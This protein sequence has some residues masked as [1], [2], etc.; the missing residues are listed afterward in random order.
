VIAGERQR[1]HSTSLTPLN[2]DR[3]G[4]SDETMDEPINPVRL[5]AIPTASANV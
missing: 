4:G 3:V 5:G 2:G 1:G